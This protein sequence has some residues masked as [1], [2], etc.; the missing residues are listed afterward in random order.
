MPK[1]RNSLLFAGLLSAAAFSVH[2]QQSGQ[3]YRWVDDEGVVH[4][5]DR[6]P[7]EYANRDRD[8]LNEQGVA[9]GFEEG[10]ITEEERAEME[11]EARREAE[12]A[13]RHAE[14]VRRDRMLLETYLSVEDIEN[15]RDRRLELLE[16]QVKVT[17]LYLTNLRKRLAELEKLAGR[18]SPHSEDENAPPMP[19]GLAGDI[20][21]TTETI[22]LYETRLEETREEQESVRESFASDIERFRELKGG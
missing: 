19:E 21:R 10:E 4:Y 3:L 8:V 6:I 18:Y 17:Q 13:E 12:E 9:V 22:S 14:R 15:L 20:A 11:R 16:S 2:A 7:P 1:A 5:G